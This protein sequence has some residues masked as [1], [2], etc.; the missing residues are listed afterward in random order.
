MNKY[1]ASWVRSLFIAL[2]CM[3]SCV[4]AGCT[5]CEP[6]TLSPEAAA[7]REQIS[8][9]RTRVGL[10]A[11]LIKHEGRQ[12]CDQTLALTN[13]N[14]RIALLREF[15]K[16]FY[17]VE[18]DKC[19]IYETSGLIGE[20]CRAPKYIAYG[21]IRAGGTDEEAWQAMVK[22]LENYKRMCL[23]HGDENDFSD[24]TS[25]DA[26]ERRRIVR[27][28][29]KTWLGCLEF[30]E[31]HSIRPVFSAVSEDAVRRYTERW[32]KKFG[33]EQEEL[34]IKYSWSL[35]STGTRHDR[36]TE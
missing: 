3:S 21:L 24:G 30:Y 13:A 6:Q 11:R 34:R 16:E 32:N 26:N 8:T 29:K 5:K 23:A 14:E 36:Q 18:I 12:L 22:G 27:W 25:A 28:A 35:P 17:A 1:N 4:A 7:C 19:N 2:L 10:N 15:V 31:K 20:Y 33:A 9:F